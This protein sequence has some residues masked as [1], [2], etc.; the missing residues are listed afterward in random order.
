MHDMSYTPSTVTNKTKIL[1]FKAAG[2][3]PPT[4]VR[5]AHRS[6]TRGYPY[7]NYRWVVAYLHENMIYLSNGFT[8][9]NA[10]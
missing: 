4:G 9:K 1:G 7:T 8:K 2:K 10:K 6:V 5:Y 3:V